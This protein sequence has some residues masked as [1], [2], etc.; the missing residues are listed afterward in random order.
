MIY[1]IPPPST[2]NMRIPLHGKVS[3]C[4]NKANASL[5]ILWVA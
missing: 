4:P 1:L 2:D 5:R 3:T